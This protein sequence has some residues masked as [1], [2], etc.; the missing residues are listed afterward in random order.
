MPLAKRWSSFTLVNLRLVPRRPG[1]YELGD[2]KGE[3]VYIGSSDAGEN[4][5]GR[6][7]SHKQSKPASVVKRFRYQ[8]CAMLDWDSAR[9]LEEEHCNIFKSQ[10]GGKLPRLQK[11]MPRSYWPDF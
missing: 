5:R 9:S 2:V 4:V 10:H 7:A 3:I 1:V 6:L 8:L 11:R